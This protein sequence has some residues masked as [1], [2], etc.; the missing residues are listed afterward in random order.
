[1]GNKTMIEKIN[2]TFINE[3]ISVIDSF[4]QDYGTFR[5]SV[6]IQ[7]Y[8]LHHQLTVSITDTKYNG[9]VR[10]VIE[11][12]LY[13]QAV[14]PSKYIYDLIKAKSEELVNKE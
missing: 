4:Q 14:I 13:E 6:T 8:A 7:S 12:T 11:Q 2:L 3:V 5:Y 10:F 1:M 9:A